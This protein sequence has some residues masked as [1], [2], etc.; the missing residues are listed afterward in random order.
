[1][2]DD[3]DFSKE[4]MSLHDDIDQFEDDDSEYEDRHRKNKKKS[5]DFEDTDEEDKDLAAIKHKKKKKKKDKKKKGLYMDD[6]IALLMDDIAMDNGLEMSDSIALDDMDEYL[7][8]KKKKKG[9]KH[10][11]FDI[12]EAKKKKK[13]D[14][15]AKFAP[16]LAQLTKILKDSD[17][18][19][20]MIK[21]ILKD[22]RGS[23]SRYV[24][25]TLT[26]LL[27]AL[28]SANSNRAS[29]VRDISNIKKAVIDLNMKKEKNTKKKKDEDID[30]E[31]YGVNIFQKILGGGSGRKE[32][33]DSAKEYFGGNIQDL[34]DG[35]EEYDLNEDINSRL[36][37]EEE[38]NNRT[39]EGSKYISYEGYGP[40][41]CVMLHSD[42]SYDIDAVDKYNQRMPD[43]YPR[44]SKEDLGDLRFDMDAM[45]AS[46]P[47]GRKFKVLN[48]L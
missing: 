41:D 6:K 48:V 18:A 42:G 27:Q 45:T 19:A 46:D 32:M 28:N 1:M 11:L 15:E 16:Q 44:L 22:I 25:K 23:K 38:N 12:K 2:K 33:M 3:F 7:L 37:E 29:V 13:K 43:D 14:L 21:D 5:D 35:M 30:N 24:G 31:S 4:F 8:S 40:E 26:D 36:R 34:D 9:K 47:Y 20:G 39:E 17:D 10:D